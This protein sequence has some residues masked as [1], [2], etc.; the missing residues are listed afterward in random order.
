MAGERSERAPAQTLEQRLR[1]LRQANEIRSRRAALKKELASGRVRIDDVL[2]QPPVYAKT[3]KVQG[4]LLAVPKVGPARAARI[5][6]RCRIAPSKT[7]K[8][9]TDEVLAW[10]TERLQELE[11]HRDGHTVYVRPELVVEIAFDG[12]QTSSRYPGG[13]ALRFAR[14]KGYRPDKRPEEADTIETVRRIHAGE[15]S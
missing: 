6:S 9:M 13:V 3:A 1:A 15:G 11:T 2:A 7:F 4:L 10:Q 8:G 14:V 12:V 5:L